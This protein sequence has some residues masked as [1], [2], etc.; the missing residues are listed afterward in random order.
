[1]LNCTVT[2]KGSYGKYEYKIDGEV[3][4]EDLIKAFAIAIATMPEKFV[5]NKPF[6]TDINAPFKVKRV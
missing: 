4:R 1:M 3:D 6:M 2:I 5:D